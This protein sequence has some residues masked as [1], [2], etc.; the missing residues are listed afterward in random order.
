MQRTLQ[1]IIFFL[2]VSTQSIYASG[3]DG[4]HLIHSIG[5]SI[6]AATAIAFLFHFLKQPLLLAYIAAGV[7][8]GPQMGF[9]F[10]SDQQDISVISEIGLILLLFMIG[11]EIDIKKL[12]ESGKAL[13]FS[14]VFQFL[15]CAILGLF[16]FSLL[17]YTMGNGKYDLFYLAVC[18]S[19]GSTA[20]VVK[21]LYSKFELDTLAGRITL[22]ILVFED[23][24]AIIVLGVQ[25][26]LADPQILQILLS[27][28][29][30]GLLVI[31]SLL[32]S[33]YILPK[34]FKSIAKIPELLLIASLGWCFLIC[35]IAGFMQLSVEMGALIAGVAISTFPYNLDVIAK[36]IS[37]RDFFITLFFVALGMQ[38]PNPLDNPKLI[39][40]AIVTALFLISTRFLSIYL[41]LYSLKQG[42]RVSLLPAI[43][44]SNIS[45]FSLVIASLGLASKH[46]DN[47]ILSTIIFVFVITSIAAP[48]MIKYNNEIQAFLAK[49]LKAIGLKD[50]ETNIDEEDQLGSQREIALLGFFKIASSFIRELEEEGISTGEPNPLL[51]KIMVVDFNPNVHDKLRTIGVKAIYGDV[52][53]MDTL[54]HSGIHHAKLVIS[55]IPDSILVGTDNLKMIKKI[56]SL[57]PH[58]K[59]I[60]TAESPDRAMRMY[61]EG[62]DY[63]M[64]PRISAARNVKEVLDAV[65]S[66]SGKELKEKHIEQLKVREEIIA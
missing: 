20:I 52:A 41:I 66:E 62:A 56:R 49:G 19:L 50:I 57:C 10:V 47:S 18:C 33:K 38:I 37:I 27:F 35:G 24:W 48:Y 61:A 45:E 42:H 7:V 4:H 22:G 5:I 30:G 40:I 2:L 51:K 54:H 34:L 9:G 39:G 31:I 60:V 55:T 29:K 32:A 53:N 14:G 23:I 28:V 3:G 16:F 25:P 26:N 17:G 65:L 64:L 6:F 43:N 44:L 58:A 12:K 59:V 1:T 8:I 15:I 46:I 11:L 36:V 13:I 63:V 21:L